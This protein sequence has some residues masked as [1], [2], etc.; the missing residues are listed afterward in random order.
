MIVVGV[1]A[2]GA[3][4]AAGR[5]LPAVGAVAA[6]PAASS[7][8]T[9]PTARSRAGAACRSPAG[10]LPRPARPLPHRDA[11]PIALGI[12]ADGGWDSHRRLDDARPGRR[13]AGAAGSRPRRRWSTSRARSPGCRRR[14]TPRRS[15]RRAAA[16][17]RAAPARAG[18][19]PFFRAFVA[20][21]FDAARAGR[22]DRRRDRRRPRRHARAGHRAGPGRGDHRGRAPAGDPHLRA[23]C[24]DAFGCVVLTPGRPAR[25]A[26]RW[27]STRCSR[28]RGV[29]LDVVVVGNGWAP[30]G[31]PDGVRGVALARGRRHPG[32]PQR[33]RRRTS[34]G[35]LLFFLDDDASLVDDDALA[36]VARAVRGGPGARRCS[37]CGVA[38]R[39]GGACSRDWVPRLRVGD[40]RAAQRRR[41]SCGR[42]RWRCRRAVFDAGRR[43]AGRVPLRRTRA[44]TS[45]GGCMDAGYRVRYAG[46]IV[47]AAPVAGA[48]APAT[49]RLLVLLR[50]AQPRLARAPPPAAAARRRST[51]LTFALRTLP[52]CARAQRCARRCAGTATGCAGRTGAPAALRARTLWRMT[53]RRPPPD[54][55]S[56]R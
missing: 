25:R 9:A 16:G 23:G 12:R 27:R 21:E 45:P 22:G 19:L 37:S 17:S 39:D 53:R 15:R 7:C 6:D 46:D 14:R 34:R 55:L 11:L 49:P 24:D 13:G 28:Q 50:R 47:G 8:S 5:R 30:T 4:D 18:R 40:P 26:A 52:R 44:S 10:H 43:L 41:R 31:L 48:R 32:R 33:R 42:A 2:A 20:I 3:A 35:E 38:P 51:S 54:H 56:H 36:R 1:L 29:E